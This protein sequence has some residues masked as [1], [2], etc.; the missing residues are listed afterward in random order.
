MTDFRDAFEQQLVD[1]SRR[2]DGSERRLRPRRW[3]IGRAPLVALAILGIGGSA[4]AAT[5][6]WSPTLG[7]DRR[8]RAVASASAPPA[9]QMG[10]L[11]VL[12]RDARPSDRDAETRAAL[13]YIGPQAD[14]VRT[15]HIRK[16]EGQAATATL[17]PAR[18]WSPAAGQVVIA[19][20]LCVEVPDTKGAAKSCWS[21]QDVRGGRA[22]GEL[23]SV[24][25]GLVPDGVDTIVVSFGAK[26]VVGQANDN[27]FAVDG[28][29]SAAGSEPV[30]AAPTAI[31]WLDE[32]GTSIGFRVLR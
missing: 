22:Y 15:D 4:L 25:Y 29:A 10:L 9:E 1:A 32:D 2:L 26:T 5:H 20:P 6:P 17:V 24:V 19:N 30:G 12:R 18:S 16:L 3:G 23:G 14:G 31:G 7:D 8:G 13:R 27:F 11:G 21:T 28:P